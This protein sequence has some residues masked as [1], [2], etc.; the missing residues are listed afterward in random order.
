MTSNAD[1][2]VEQFTRQAAPFAN[3]TAMRDEDALRLLVE[4][5][6]AGVSDTCSMS[7]AVRG[8]W[9]R[10]S[11]TLAGTLSASTSPLR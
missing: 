8:S 7:H 1:I 3:S 10:P 4:F 11:R 6:G 5:S 2:V 9:L